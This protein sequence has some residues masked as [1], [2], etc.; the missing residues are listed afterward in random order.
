MVT[1]KISSHTLSTIIGPTLWVTSHL[2]F[3]RSIIGFYLARDA[4]H[5]QYGEIVRIA[6]KEINFAKI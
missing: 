1:Y 5:K 2:T 4:Y 3:L 6:H